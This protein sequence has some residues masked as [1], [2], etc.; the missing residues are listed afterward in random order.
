LTQPTVTEEEEDGTEQDGNDDPNPREDENNNTRKA[1]IHDLCLAVKEAQ[2]DQNTQKCQLLQ[3]ATNMLLTKYKTSSSSFLS[4]D[5]SLLLHD[6]ARRNNQETARFMLDV[7][8]VDPN[9]KG[10]QG[11]TPLQFAARSGKTEMVRFLLSRNGIDPTIQD[12]RGNTA[13]DAARANQKN[14]IVAILMEYQDNN[15]H[16]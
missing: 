4:F 5:T 6:A 2:R 7:I 14:D 11:M 8:G 10:R 15:N 13:L 9:T 16:I 12:D 3:Q 1:I